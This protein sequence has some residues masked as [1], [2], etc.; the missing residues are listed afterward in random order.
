[1]SKSKGNIV[2]PQDILNK[3]GAEPFRLWCAVEGDIS[4]S[5]FRCSFERIEGAGKTIIKLWNVSRF[6]SMFEEDGSA[7]NTELDNWILSELNSLVKTATESYENY[8]FHKPATLIRHFIWETFASHYLELVKNRAYNESNNFTKE[9]QNAAI[10]TL[11]SC[12]DTT[13]KL[14]APVVPMVT[15]KIYKDLTGKDIHFE[16]FPK[17][18][19]A[20][21]EINTQKLIELNSTIWKA[22][23]DKGL[24]LKAEIPEATLPEELKVIEKDLKTTHNIQKISYGKKLEVKI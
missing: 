3:Y 24:S 14:L 5:D 20:A 13:L 11:N 8:D 17:V 22:K 23:K 6:I 21:T 4:S 18:T 9:E 1:M 2:D 16:E 19:K 7:K 10:K 12:L 15:Y